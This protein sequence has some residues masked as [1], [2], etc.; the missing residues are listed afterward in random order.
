MVN[1]FIKISFLDVK[2]PWEFIERVKMMID[3][4][5]KVPKAVKYS[6]VNWYRG[7]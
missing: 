3:P 7:I 6:I 1:I 5:G 2:L 4:T